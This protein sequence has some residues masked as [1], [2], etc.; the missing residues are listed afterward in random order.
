MSDG[1]PVEAEAVV[2]EGGDGSQAVV[3]TLPEAT[4]EPAPEA[5]A[6]EAVADSAVEIARIEADASVAREEIRADVEIVAIEARAEGEE[7]VEEWQ[8]EMT[9]LRTDLSAVADAVA[10]MA[11]VVDQLASQST[12]PA[13]PAEPTTPPEAMTDTSATGTET[14]SATG[15][16]APERS[17]VESPAP[18]VAEMRRKVRMI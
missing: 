9:L 11:V 18:L 10:A 3:V 1:T 8:M 7:R 5:E 2:V 15:T 12:P 13:S 17:A 14:S 4:T 16:E 6:V